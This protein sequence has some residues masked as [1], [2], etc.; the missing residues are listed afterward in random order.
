[1]QTIQRLTVDV[2]CRDPKDRIYAKQGDEEGRVLIVTLTDKGETI[3]PGRSESAVFRCMKPDGHTVIQDCTINE[4]GEIEV[5]L[6]YQILA[7]PG[8]VAA[9]V[10]LVDGGGRVLSSANFGIQVEAMPVTQDYSPSGVEGG[11]RA[12]GDLDMAGFRIHNLDNPQQELDAVN[13][14]Y[15]D[16]ALMLKADRADTEMRLDSLELAEEVDTRILTKHGIWISE[17]QQAM[18]RPVTV[19]AVQGL[20]ETLHDIENALDEAEAAI[21]N[22]SDDV[23]GVSTEA[24][25]AMNVAESANQLAARAFANTQTLTSTTE[26]QQDQINAMDQSIRALDET[27]ED[28]GTRIAAL[29]AG[30]GSGITDAQQQLLEGALQ[31]TGDTMSGDLHMASYKLLFG[32]STKQAGISHPFPQGD[33]RLNLE[34]GS[35]NPIPLGG[36]DTP[37]FNTDAA[38]KSYVDGCVQQVQLQAGEGIRIENGVISVSYPDGNDLAY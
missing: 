32:P 18:E 23:K 37:K 38:N 7:V 11:M 21:T 10:S 33:N 16:D 12:Y 24:Q 2:S 29:E 15:V 8:L 9:D 4:S 25:G 36:V 35:G 30:G 5:T 3:H 17:L 1:M 28:H 34:D 19:E 22:L 14:K 20:R 6:T 31:R 27:A 26:A 13:R